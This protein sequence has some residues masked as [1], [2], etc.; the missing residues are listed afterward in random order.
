VHPCC[1]ESLY[2][3]SSFPPL[4]ENN[5][6]IVINHLLIFFVER[7]LSNI[8]KAELVEMAKKMRVVANMPNDS[9]TQKKKAP[10]TITQASTEQDEKTTSG[11]AFKR[12]RKAT[13]P[14]TEHSHSDNR[15]PH[16]DVAHS[17]GHALHQDVI[18]I[19][20]CEAESSKR[21]S[22]W[23]LEFDIPSYA[24]TTFLPSEDKDRL[25]ARDEDKL[26]CDM[27]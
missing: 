11:L 26:L 4:G 14:S 8:S 15:A 6:A 3:Y 9:L 22:L 13:A 24:E 5:S 27:M 20:E 12:K 25:M 21:K 17:V 10:V 19:Q 18:V 7:M 16:Q 23:D 1:F 2:W